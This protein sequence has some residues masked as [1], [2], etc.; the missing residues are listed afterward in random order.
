MVIGCDDAALQFHELIDVV[1]MRD[2]GLILIGN[3][4][5]LARKKPILKKRVY[6]F[7]GYC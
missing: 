7:Y 3:A 5:L 4:H 6:S 1:R 2:N